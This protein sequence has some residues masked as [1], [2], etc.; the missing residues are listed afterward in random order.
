MAPVRLGVIGC[1]IAAR[2]LHWPAIKQLPRKFTIP[3]V[4]NHTE[5]KARSFA[6]LV[7]AK[8]WVLDYR[9]VLARDD[10]DA[11]SI[12]LPV[13]LNAEVTRAALKAGKHVMLEKPIATNRREAA[14]LVK[15][16]EASP[17]VAMI[18]ENFRYRPLFRKLRTLLDKGG[19]GT[20][21]TVQW[22]TLG[23]LTPDNKYMHTMWRID[24]KYPGGFVMDA[25]V[26]T[27]NA[28]RYLFGEI[29]SVNARSHSV[30]RAIGEIDTLTMQFATERGIAGTWMSSFS[31]RGYSDNHLLIMGDGGTVSMRGDAIEVLPARG[32]AKTITGPN[33]WGYREEYEAFH[34]AIQNGTGTETSFAEGYRDFAVI[35]AALESSDKGRPVTPH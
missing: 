18:A 32:K 31:C 29:N 19:I 17:L 8:E 25:G 10:V 13:E 6:Q 2:E 34:A 15:T 35:L 4:C 3:V 30:N 22:T 12:I 24:H 28:M 11:V 5:P 14:A 33:S 20:V 7:G 23:N 16:A 9:D 1:G 21:H 27:V 26:H